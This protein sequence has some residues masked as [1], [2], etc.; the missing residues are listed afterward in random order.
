M[1]L[2]VSISSSWISLVAQTRHFLDEV[3]AIGEVSS[4]T[5]AM[6]GLS[7][8]KQVRLNN[9]VCVKG[10]PVFVSWV[11]TTECAMFWRNKQAP[12]WGKVAD[13]P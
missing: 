4:D 7:S 11:L 2:P 6:V 8:E 10:L 9:V 13:S 3:S 5:W 1:I 12:S